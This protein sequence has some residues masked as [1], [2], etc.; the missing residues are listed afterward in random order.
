MKAASSTP[1]GN[2]KDWWTKE[3]RAKFDERT[4][5]VRRPV[6][7]YVVVDDIHVNGKLTLGEDVADMGGEIL[8]YMAWKDDDERQA[9]AARRWPDAGTAL[10]RRLRAVGLRERASGRSAGARDDR[11]AFAGAVSA[12]TAWW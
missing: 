4:N 10:L 5:C 6:F 9:S 12:S 7:A 2:L 1:Q 8:A 3:D 11:S